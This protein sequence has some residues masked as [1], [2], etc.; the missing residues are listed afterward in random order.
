MDG[1]GLHVAMFS[2]FHPGTLGGI[3]NSVNDQR[4]EL[5]RRGHR[6]T[7]FTPPGPGEDPGTVELR[8]VLG[9]QVNGFPAV[10]PSRANTRIVDEALAG[11]GCDVVHVHTTY[12]VGAIGAKH[13]A[14]HGIP[15][16][17]TMHSRDDRF[18]EANSPNPAASALALRLLHSAFVPHRE[19][20]PEVDE[21]AAAHNAWRVMIAQARAADAVIAPTAHFA[22]RLREHGLE[23]PLHVISGGVDDAL[24]P[25]E[26]RRPVEPA[27]GPLRA[28]WC[29]R[30]SPEKRPL[31]AIE[32]VLATPGVTL[33]VLGDGPLLDAARDLAERDGRIRIHGRVGR[34]EV[35]A[36]MRDHDV[37]LFNS[38][39][40]ETQGLVALEAAA[41]GTP[42][43]YSDPNLAENVP[44]GAGFRTRDDSAEAIAAELA[45]LRDRPD[46]LAAARAAA[47]SADVRQSARTDEIEVLYLDQITARARRRTALPTDPSAVPG[48]P[49][50]LPV[51]G[52]SAVALRKGLDFIRD[53]GRDGPVVRIDL[54]PKRAY[55]LTTPE[56]IREVGFRTAG[57][58]HRRDV[59]ESMHEAVRGASNV[60][61]GEAHDL[62]RRMIAP[63]LRSG[64][65][66]EYAGTTARIADEWAQSL[67]FDRRVDLMIEAHGLILR[68][69]T[70]TLFTADFG[71]AA[72]E[73]I[74]QDMPWL[75]SQVI[76]RGALPASV[77]RLR[78]RANRRFSD[79]AAALR[80]EIGAVVAAYRTAD[81]ERNDVL[82]AL[83]RHVDP[84]TGATLSDDEVTDELILMVAAGVGSTASILAWVWHEI[85]SDEAVAARVR[86]EVSEVVGA[87]PAGPEHLPRLEYLRRTVQETLRMWGPWISSQNA[88][89]SVEFG[90]GDAAGPDGATL[91]LPTDSMIVYSPYLVHH[92]PR[93]YTDPDRF[94]PDRW[95]AERAHEIDKRAVLPFGVGE[96]HCPGSNFAVTII[97]LA[98][99]S[100][101]SSR[102]PRP[103]GGPPSPSTTDFVPAPSALPV[104]L[105]PRAYA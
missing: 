91:T 19:G 80:R 21:S 90:R 65:I 63:A 95:T 42:L 98:T 24:L 26:E 4:R 3:Q 14:R 97:L 88:D 32:A 96:R 100:L 75:L 33:D 15:L 47:R 59:Q 48:A 55:V 22:A 66:A 2:D 53:L 49:G 83:V 60:L 71:A 18:L 1:A 5:E 93:Y 50:A 36:A 61:C 40:Y 25:A 8:P 9:L 51:L 39:G 44:E 76:V 104:V 17:Q 10:L 86:A 105:G 89:G 38:S 67:P 69:V 73:R 52:H 28:V 30:I 87:G 45:A 99:A 35:I 85:M 57:E 43:L 68:T 72:S 74:R 78:L 27:G 34:P 20:I 103:V 41:A 82:S 81:E 84:E 92:D 70:S 12:G 29:G 79:K 46:R 94:D 31:E 54:G 77:Q 16:V 23:T 58:F 37:V 56:L 6:V 13:A 101:Y 102:E 7:L 11:H 62:R 64:R